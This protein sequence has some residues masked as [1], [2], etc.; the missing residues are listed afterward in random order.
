MLTLHVVQRLDQLM[1]LLYGICHIQLTMKSIKAQPSVR[2]QENETIVEA[3]EILQAM[4]IY[5]PAPWLL[6]IYHKAKQRGE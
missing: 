1:E 3:I 2:V 6:R 5:S 4:L